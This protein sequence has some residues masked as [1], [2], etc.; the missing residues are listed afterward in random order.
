MRRKTAITAAA[1]APTLAVPSAI[2]AA[3]SAPR[4]SPTPKNV[5]ID[6]AAVKGTGCRAGSVSVDVSPY[7]DS[8]RVTYYQYLAEA[9]N[10]LDP[11]LSRVDCTVTLKM[12]YTRGFTYTVSS[13]D[14]RG[15]AFLQPGTEAS[16]AAGYAYEGERYKEITH[17]VPGPY[18]NDLQFT[19]VV[20]DSQLAWLPCGNYRHLDLIRRPTTSPGSNARH[21]ALNEGATEPARIDRPQ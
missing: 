15:Y 3:A 7:H 14:H 16:Q 12:R 9:G 8:F 1:R 13:T 4:F 11:A 19:D 6:I 2:P 20:P 5:Y 10:G 21:S 18:K 17:L